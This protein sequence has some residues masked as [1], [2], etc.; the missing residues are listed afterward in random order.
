MMFHDFQR[1]QVGAHDLPKE[2]VH[3]SLF[4]AFGPKDGERRQ[5]SFF[6]YIYNIYIYSLVGSRS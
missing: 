3:R 2:N 6:I 1:F 4:P 5:L